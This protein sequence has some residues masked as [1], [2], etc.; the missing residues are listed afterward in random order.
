[1]TWDFLGLKRLVTADSTDLKPREGFF[2][3]ENFEGEN[4]SSIGG[5][6]FD[7]KVSFR[8]LALSRLSIYFNENK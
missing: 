1:L 7:L 4:E 5:R 3:Q 8:F 2:K 6:S